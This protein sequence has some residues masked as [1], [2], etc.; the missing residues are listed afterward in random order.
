MS[1]ILVELA[2]GAVVFASTNVDDL[3]VLLGFFSDPRFTARQVVT[4]QIVGIAALTAA[5]LACSIA[6]LALP[7]AY[8]GLLGFAPLALGLWKLVQLR[9]AE[10]ADSPSEPSRTNV[11]A[12]AAVTIANGGD[13]I[14]VYVPLF[15]T[16]RPWEMALLGGTFLGMTVLW[17]AIAHRLVHHPALGKPIRRY[18]QVLLPIVLILLGAIILVESGALR[19]S[20]S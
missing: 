12:V 8:V 15:A 17:C 14:A 4:G 9:R 16:R 10:S 19:L 20:W 7:A 18:G 2:L 5:S 13:N 3:V 1:H 11:L 6:T